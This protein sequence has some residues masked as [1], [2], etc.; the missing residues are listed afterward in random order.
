MVIFVVILWSFE[1]SQCSP[2][3]LICAW[4]KLRAGGR[5]VYIIGDMSTG[6]CSFV[7]IDVFYGNISLSAAE[8]PH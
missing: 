2:T 5:C 8:Q 6:K 3:E 7:E 1:V 4:E